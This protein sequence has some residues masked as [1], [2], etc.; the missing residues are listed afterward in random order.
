MYYFKR[1]KHLYNGWTEEVFRETFCQEDLSNLGFCLKVLGRFFSTHCTRNE[2][3]WHV[4][5]KYVFKKVS[6]TQRTIVLRRPYHTVD[7]EAKMSFKNLDNK[8]MLLAHHIPKR[9]ILGTEKCTFGLRLKTLL[10]L[11]PYS[12]GCTCILLL[13]LFSC[14]IFF[15]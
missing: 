11:C 8:C 3:L 6:H 15:L 10:Q 12:L 7:Q 5:G 9:N 14:E 4:T 1:L 2:V 13:M